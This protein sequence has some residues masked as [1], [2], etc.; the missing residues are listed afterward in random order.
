M[1]TTRYKLVHFYEPQF[2]YWELF[3]LEKDSHELKSV[4]GRPEY[5]PVQ[6]ELAADLASSRKGLK[7]PEKDPPETMIGRG[8]AKPKR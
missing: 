6:R 2:N 5:A 4:Y 7:V 8:P 3:D 1:V